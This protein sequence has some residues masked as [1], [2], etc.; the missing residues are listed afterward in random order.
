MALFLVVATEAPRSGQRKPRR[1]RFAAAAETAD[2]ALKAWKA[3]HYGAI[4]AQGPSDTVKV[5]PEPYDQ[6]VIRI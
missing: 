2:E 3:S 6:P 4:Y 1:Y 5:D